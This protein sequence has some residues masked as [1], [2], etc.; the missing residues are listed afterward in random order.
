MRRGV[1]WLPTMTCH[2][3]VLTLPPLSLLQLANKA[4]IEV[5]GAKASKTCLKGK[6]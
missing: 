4:C 3:L 2:S 1:G 6:M 5:T